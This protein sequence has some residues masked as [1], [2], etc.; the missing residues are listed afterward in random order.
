MLKLE[1]QWTNQLATP[2]PVGIA[3]QKK[4]KSV[5]NDTY[6]SKV[7][8]FNAGQPLFSL[9]YPF[10]LPPFPRARARAKTE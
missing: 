4:K 8:E 3:G 1:K 7:L 2:F 10:S 6:G 5:I 9:I